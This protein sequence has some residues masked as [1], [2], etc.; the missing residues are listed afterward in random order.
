M[1]QRGPVRGW[2]DLHHLYGHALGY[3]KTEEQIHDL[4]QLFGWE[5]QLTG[6]VP[7]YPRYGESRG[8]VCWTCGL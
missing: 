6:A 5:K 1:Q 8:W 3:S 2:T 7:S 4:A